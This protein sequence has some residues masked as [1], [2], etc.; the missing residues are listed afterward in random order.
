MPRLKLLSLA[1]LT[2]LACSPGSVAPS[3]SPEEQR[4]LA[5]PPR[6]GFEAVAS[7]LL[8]TCGTLDCHGRPERNMRLFGNHAARLSP[9]DDPGGAPTRPPEYDADYWSVIG[10][11][12]E[13]MDLV[14]RQHGADPERLSLIRK[15]RGTERHKGGTL[16]QP[17]DALDSCL[18]GWLRGSPDAA[19]CM[20]VGV[21]RPGAAAP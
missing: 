3:L 5:A 15:P 19:I 14:V 10:L 4:P 8:V 21:Q 6:A 1:L 16:M 12:P 13:A 20:T 2:A 7:A 18:R 11:E 17:G 9:D